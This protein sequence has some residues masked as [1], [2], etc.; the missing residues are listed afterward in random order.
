MLARL[1]AMCASYAQNVTKK[2]MDSGCIRV[3]KWGC[4]QFTILWAPHELVLKTFEWQLIN[5]L[6]F[7]TLHWINF[8]K[9]TYKLISHFL[10]LPPVNYL[11]LIQTIIINHVSQLFVHKFH[12]FYL[13]VNNFCS[14]NKLFKKK[15][16][17]VLS[18]PIRLKLE[19]F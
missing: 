18:S 1:Q 7:S 3:S 4:Y 17:Y 19:Q 15:S 5:T 8:L 9:N 10:I 16:K 6:R 14:W 12:K 13:F 2:F 11:I